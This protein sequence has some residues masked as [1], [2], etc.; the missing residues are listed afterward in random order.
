MKRILLCLLCCGLAMPSGAAE[1]PLTLEAKISLGDVK[2]RID[3]F[4]IDLKRQKL[5]VAELGNDS[6][7]VVDL[8][9]RKLLHQMTGFAEPQGVAHVRSSDML[10]VANARDGGL[11]LFRAQDYA[12]IGRFELGSDADNIR[13]D[14]KSDRVFVGYGDGAL[15]VIDAASRRLVA[16]FKFNAHPESFQ[17]DTTSGKIFVNLPNAHEIAVLDLASGK[18]LAAWPTPDAHANFPMALDTLNRRVLVGF[19]EPSKLIGYAMDDGRIATQT[20]LCGDVDDLFVDTKRGRVY[21]SCGAGFIDVL[22]ADAGSYARIARLP[23]VPGARTALWVAELDRLFVAVRA[24]AGEPAA[25]WIYR[26]V[27]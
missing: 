25:V 9:Q 14:D 2:G 19:R 13:V 4:A 18:L 11:E 12:P 23:T 15:A 17:I 27:P 21:A 26:A 10:Y 6:V 16:R 5:Y 24:T 1:A 22:R 20:D 8:A 3:H 7:G